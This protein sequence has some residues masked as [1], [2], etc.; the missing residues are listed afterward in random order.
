[1][2][3]GILH[4]KHSRAGSAASGIPVPSILLKTSLDGIDLSMRICIVDGDLVGSDSHKRAVFLM[5]CVDVM[6]ALSSDDCQFQSQ[7]GDS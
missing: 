3:F 5:L 2:G 4:R 7:V 1:M 6:D